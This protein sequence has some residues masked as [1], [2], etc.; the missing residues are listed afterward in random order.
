MAADRFL[1]I[2]NNA[3]EQWNSTK[4]VQD[5]LDSA[6]N[7]MDGTLG[8]KHR[9][10]AF[11]Y[12]SRLLKEGRRSPSSLGTL[13]SKTRTR[14]IRQRSE[15]I[16]VQADK[17]VS[18]FLD[19]LLRTYLY[20]FGRDISFSENCILAVENHVRQTRRRQRP[21]TTAPINLVIRTKKG[22]GPQNRE[23]RIVILSELFDCLTWRGYINQR[24]WKAVADVLQS[25]L[26]CKDWDDKKGF[27]VSEYRM[28]S[29]ILE[30]PQ[31]VGR[32]SITFSELKNR[33][34]ATACYLYETSKVKSQ[35]RQA[36]Q[37]FSE[38]MGHRQ[39]KLSFFLRVMQAACMFTPLLGE[40]LTVFPFLCFNGAEQ[41]LR[42]VVESTLQS[43]SLEDAWNIVDTHLDQRGSPDFYFDQYSG[44]TVY[45][46]AEED[47]APENCNRTIKYL[48]LLSALP[49]EESE[50]S[51]GNVSQ[52]V[53]QILAT[54][55]AATATSG[56]EAGLSE[57]APDIGFELRKQI[58]NEKLHW[59]VYALVAAD[60]L[61][62]IKHEGKKLA[63]NIAVGTELEFRAAL[64][65]IYKFTTGNKPP[66]IA[67]MPNPTLSVENR[68]KFQNMLR[69]IVR[70]YFTLLD[71]RYR[72]L[73][74]AV[75]PNG[76]LE[77]CYIADA[78][79]TMYASTISET[80]RSLV[81]EGGFALCRVESSGK[82]TVSARDEKGGYKTLFSCRPLGREFKAWT[83]PMA[84]RI[85]LS[86]LN[87][88]LTALSPNDKSWGSFVTY[89]LAPTVEA[90]SESPS[91]GGI[92]V[93]VRDLKRLTT[94]RMQSGRYFRMPEGDPRIRITPDDNIEYI[95]RETL[96][97]L[98]V[99]DGA[100][101]INVKSGSVTS[102]IQLLG[103]LGKK[104]FE[105]VL[106]AEVPT[107]YKN[108]PAE[109]GTRHLS[110]LQFV[111]TILNGRKPR[112]QLVHCLVIS[113]DGDV[114]YMRDKRDHLFTEVI[115]G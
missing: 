39:R 22:K 33:A 30:K 84:K 104:Q 51:T 12:R 2:V 16:K 111:A 105:D 70:R 54:L 18:L 87:N 74:I 114:H 88:E 101:V 93:V 72:F 102:R 46:D 66:D 96:R 48:R 92:V 45:W 107:E 47:I 38:V 94:G 19:N 10:A 28:V 64:V 37:R 31:K 17:W 41:S 44:L 8:A 60:V 35:I 83:Q 63:L 36:E 109:W 79:E 57:A 76:S 73:C 53:S 58:G 77:L 26:A 59:P 103:A 91:E 81:M 23:K 106:R 69:I 6:K 110:A 65:P 9:Y 3:R 43:P 67:M 50:Q 1:N 68:R 21:L 5:V 112:K 71:A 75:R 56:N 99:Q 20:V 25:K 52:G 89:I 86:D 24:L 13:R 113:Q 4:D 14:V 27:D 82:A 90:I 100:T 11:H 97:R 78:M 40:N 29:S 32:E 108:R 55:V 95:D 115:I 7:V 61:R 15:D 98:V 62:S 80:L 34:I 49:N 42:H 85:Y